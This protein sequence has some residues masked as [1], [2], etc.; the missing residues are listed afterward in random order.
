MLGADQAADC[1]A[2]GACSALGAC[3]DEARSMEA[4]S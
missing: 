4:A 2:C 1:A 3:V